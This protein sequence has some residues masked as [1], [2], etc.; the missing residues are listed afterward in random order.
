MNKTLRVS[1]GLLISAGCLWFLFRKF[2]FAA[3]GATLRGASYFW[4]VAVVLAFSC[5]M[6]CRSFRWK[7]LLSPLGELPLPVVF[8]KLLVGFFMNNILPARGGEV[9]R[10]VALARDTGIPT[11]SI[12]GSIVAERMT[13]MT[14]LVMIILMASRLLPWAKLPVYPIIA[15]L[16]LG[17]AGMIGLIV[18]A[19]RTSAGGLINRITSGFLALRSPSKIISVVLL[20]WAVWMGELLIVFFVAR[21]LHLNLTFFES[22]GVLTGLSVGVMIPAAPGYVGTYEFFGKAALTLL[23]KPAAASLAF[24]LVLHFFQLALVAL[25]ALPTLIAPKRV[26]HAA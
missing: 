9:V 25:A 12:L 7:I 17:V 5:N 23:G 24:V 15:A 8:P 19:K 20:S 4:F 18:I 2:D 21:A 26:L 14:G 13:D 22:A 3:L 6:I 1:V 11:S 16:L 10:A